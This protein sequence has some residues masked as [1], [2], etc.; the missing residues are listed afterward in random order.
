MNYGYV[1][2]LSGERYSYGSADTAVTTGDECHFACQLVGAFVPRQVLGLWRHI[3]L[4]SGLLCLMLSLYGFCRAML[5]FSNCHGE[6]SRFTE[7]IA[8]CGESSMLNL[9]IDCRRQW[10]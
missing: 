4:L 5:S 6:P 8:S 2:T 3:V 9:N 7:K 1:G 10:V